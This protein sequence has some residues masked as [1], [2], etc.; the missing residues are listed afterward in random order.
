M[1]RAASFI[2][3]GLI[4]TSALLAPD[5]SAA[6]AGQPATPRDE[7]IQLH[8]RMIDAHKQAIHCLQSGQPMD[9]C[10]RFTPGEPVTLNEAE[11]RRHSKTHEAAGT[12]AKG[13]SPP[14]AWIP[15]SH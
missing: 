13:A 2:S 3:L 9:R 6:Q 12:A 5:A 14:P 7:S 15:D 10:E 8:Q 4:M 1:I 11:L